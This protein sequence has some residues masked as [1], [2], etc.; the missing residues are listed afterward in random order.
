MPDSKVQHAALGALSTIYDQKRLD[1]D[2][3]G[4]TRMTGEQY[5]RL[6]APLDALRV[7]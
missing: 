6:K 4:E 5:E 2:T 1:V 7:Y 3:D